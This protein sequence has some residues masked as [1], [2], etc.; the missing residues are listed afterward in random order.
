MLVLVGSFLI[1]TS[2]HSTFTVPLLQRQYCCDY[3]ALIGTFLKVHEQS[4]L[5]SF[6]PLSL[7]ATG[8]TVIAAFLTD[9]PKPLSPRFSFTFMLRETCSLKFRFSC[10][11][12][13]CQR[14]KFCRGSVA[15]RATRSPSERPMI[16][17]NTSLL[18]P[19]SPAGPRHAGLTRVAAHT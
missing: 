18:V 10:R 7:L 2:S 13:C 4:A 15:T 1:A 5:P 14:R 16:H 3:L 6:L 17:A 19:E 12:T 11:Y 8:W 9:T